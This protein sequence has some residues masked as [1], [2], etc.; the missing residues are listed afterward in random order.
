MLSCCC[1]RVF[2]PSGYHES[3]LKMTDAAV[4][5]SNWKYSDSGTQKYIEFM[6]EY[7]HDYVSNIIPSQPFFCSK[8]IDIFLE[9]F[10]QQDL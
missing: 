9:A 4:V 2:L 5:V 1:V 8:F 7:T 3:Q 6:I 10:M